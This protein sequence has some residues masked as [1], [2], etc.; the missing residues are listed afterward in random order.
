MLPPHEKY[1]HGSVSYTKVPVARPVSPETR[2][3][4]HLRPTSASGG[5]L[6]ILVEW[7]GK[8][9]DVVFVL[10]LATTVRRRDLTEGVGLDASE[11]GAGRKGGLRALRLVAADLRQR[12]SRQLSAAAAVLRSARFD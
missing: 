8:I 1:P 5:L 9:P 12:L 10:G 2:Y 7:P 11:T 4:G 3:H 6:R